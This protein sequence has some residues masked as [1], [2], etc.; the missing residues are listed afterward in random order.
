[1]AQASGSADLGGT[2]A[3]R[4]ILKRDDRLVL[5]QHARSTGTDSARQPARRLLSAQSLSPLY[6]QARARLTTPPHVL[7]VAAT[8]RVGTTDVASI[9]VRASPP[10]STRW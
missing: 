5:A 2:S 6:P 7:P 1:M 4:W 3:A 10:I 9:A 8:A